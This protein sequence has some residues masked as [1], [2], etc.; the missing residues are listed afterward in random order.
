MS[1]WV[2]LYRSAVAKKAVMATTG[3]VLFGYVLLHM[4]GNLKIFQGAES[5]NHYAEWLREVG[6]PLVPHGGVLWLVRVV[7]LAS[8]VLHIWSALELTLM[9]RAARPDDYSRRSPVQIDFA[10][11]TMR[12]TGVLVGLYI[13]YHLMDLTLGNVHQGFVAGDPYHNVVS[14]FQ[15]WPVATVYIAANLLLGFH[16]YHG[17]WS[18]FQSLGWN[19]SGYGGWRRGFAITFCSLV[20]LGFISVPLAVLARVVS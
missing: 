3:F 15:L 20:T 1:W 11:R 16:L 6:Y 9:S 18:M 8:I 4:A 19:D 10:A 2:E 7:L 12:W 14:G 13:V 17:L 5:F